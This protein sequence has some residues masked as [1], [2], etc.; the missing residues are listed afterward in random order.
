MTMAE[1]WVAERPARRRFAIPVASLSMVGAG[2]LVLV[3]FVSLLYLAQTSGVATSGYDLQTIESE[4]MLLKL[5]NDQLRL[6]IAQARSLER[7]ELD[8]R[9]RLKMAPPERVIYVSRP[10]TP[11]PDALPTPTDPLTSAWTTVGNAAGSAAA[12]LDRRD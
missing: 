9:T 10:A 1:S 4:R 6:Q 11:R 7:V 2:A 8:A 12:W 3:A 5:R